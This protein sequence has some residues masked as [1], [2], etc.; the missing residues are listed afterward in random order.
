MKGI[1]YVKYIYERKL[2]MKYWKKIIIDGIET[3]YSVSTEGEVRNDV[4]QTI[5]TQ[6][7]EYEYQVVAISVG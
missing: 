1:E 4:R 6:Q 7:I 3:N 5:L 2:K